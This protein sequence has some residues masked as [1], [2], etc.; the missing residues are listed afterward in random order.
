MQLGIRLEGIVKCDEEWG[1]AD[2]LQHLPLSA[3][4]LSGLGLLHN[5]GL[6][7]HLH[8]VQLPRIVATHL[9]HQE[10]LSVCWGLKQPE[11]RGQ[12]AAERIWSYQRHRRLKRNSLPPVP[13][14]FRSSKF[15]MPT[16]ST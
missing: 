16:R 7:Q 15:S 3:R 11:V 10:H 13:S 1:L 5:R 6:F 12:C 9:P 14:T 2:V 8:G 4:V